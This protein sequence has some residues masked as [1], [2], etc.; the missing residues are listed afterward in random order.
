MREYELWIDE[1][2]RFDPEEE[3]NEDLNP[4]LIGGILIEKGKIQRRTIT[5]LVNKDAVGVVHVNKYGRALMRD[6]VHAGPV[7]LPALKR[8]L[9][10]PKKELKQATFTLEVLPARPDYYTQDDE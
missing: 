7:I 10:R 4:S 1:S 8:V 3:E 2:G 9:Q 6:V 5:Q